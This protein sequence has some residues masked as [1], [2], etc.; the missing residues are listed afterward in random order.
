MRNSSKRHFSPVSPFLGLAILGMVALIV[1]LIAQAGSVEAHGDST[2]EIS[3]NV[4]VAEAGETITVDASGF[5]VGTEA[6]FIYASTITVGGMPIASV[7]SVDPA[8]GFL[9]AGRTTDS[10]LYIAEHIDIDP[11]DTPP[12]GAFTAEFVLPAGLPAGEHELVVTSCWGGADE[13]YPED[14][15]APCGKVGLGGG[16]ND[17]VATA[18]LVVVDASPAEL[19]LDVAVAEQG[20]T[21]TVEASGFRM[22]TEASFIYAST[23]TVGGVPI[24]SVASVDSG[25][26]FLHAGR[27]TDS[28]LYIAE[29]I[30]IDPADTTPDGAFTADLVLPDDLPTGVHYLEVTSCWGGA[31]ESYP[32]DGVMP[33]GGVGLGGGVNDR[34]ARAHIAVVD[35]SPAEL[36]LSVSE[37][38]PGDTI[39]V[40][41][42]GFRVGTEASFIYASTITIGGRSITRVASVDSSSGFLHAGRTTDSGLYIA[43]H[44]D[45]DPADTTADGEFTA[46]FVL[47]RSLPAGDLE[48]VVTSCWGGADESY[49]EDGVAPCGKVGLG[50]GVNDRV[51]KTTI[52]IVPA[53]APIIIERVQAQ[54]CHQIGVCDFF[55]PHPLRNHQSYPN[56]K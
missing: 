24:A 15:V 35:A 42:S 44:I 21:I 13:S 41:A 53:R 18:N 55:N 17:R 11:A 49:P 34:T 12:D 38:A 16:V 26:G 50:G 23:I 7:A 20:E 46:S 27:T 33:C 9:H 5:R 45:I 19:N 31:D 36:N 51:A 28:G 4:G 10:G 47:P 29:H 56:W 2:A 22:G 52:T 40:D 3:L 48:L 43:E 6:S 37:A 32:E 14:G 8:S 25:S 1:M 30:D 54:L 39:T